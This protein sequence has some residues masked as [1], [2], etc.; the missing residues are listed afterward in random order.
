MCRA[1]S[2]VLLWVGPRVPKP[3]LTKMGASRQRERTADHWGKK[4]GKQSLKSHCQVGKC[5]GRSTKAAYR[6]TAARGRE[7][8]SMTAAVSEGACRAGAPEPAGLRAPTQQSPQTPRL[9]LPLL[10]APPHS[11]THQSCFWKA[12][13][14][15]YF[16]QVGWRE[17][18][19]P[20]QPTSITSVVIIREKL[21]KCKGKQCIVGSKPWPLGSETAQ[22]SKQLCCYLAV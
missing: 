22:M 5:L 13:Y 18:F 7:A 10:P 8:R 17:D 6:M 15:S 9:K 21:L 1:L 3:R 4:G 20:F 2:S 14:S 12:G 19:K 11:H 16:K